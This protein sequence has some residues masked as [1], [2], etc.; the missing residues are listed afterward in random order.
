MHN[1]QDATNSLIAPIIQT[2]NELLGKT[3]KKLAKELNRTIEEVRADVSMSQDLYKA[4]YFYRGD[5]L[6]ARFSICND[7]TGGLFLKCETY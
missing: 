7:G 3:I 6:I 1:I 5:M 2:Q 4:N